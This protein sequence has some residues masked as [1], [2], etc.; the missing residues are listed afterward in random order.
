MCD[1]D[2]GI[3]HFL[4][5]QSF[6][7]QLGLQMALATSFF[8]AFDCVY[9]GQSCQVV[10]VAATVNVADRGAVC[11]LARPHVLWPVFSSLQLQEDMPEAIFL[12]GIKFH[13]AEGPVRV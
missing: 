9:A 4:S 5:R 3:M 7:V 10:M 13:V 11:A 8:F 12:Q 2:F 1:M 6:P